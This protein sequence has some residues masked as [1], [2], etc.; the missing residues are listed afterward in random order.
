MSGSKIFN[1]MERPAACATLVPLV[2]E[3][4]LHTLKLGPFYFNGWR[5]G[6]VVARRTCDLVVAGSRPG[7]D[8]A[9]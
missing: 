5:V 6:L 2:L 9:A 4:K 8:A 1:D 7:R 3:R